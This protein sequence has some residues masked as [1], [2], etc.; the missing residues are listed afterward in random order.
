MPPSFPD[1]P[2][3]PA[4][5]PYQPPYKN[6][7][8]APKLP[9]EP[10]NAEEPSV[11]ELIEA[12]EPELEELDF[13]EPELIETGELG[14][15]EPELIETE[16]PGLEELEFIEAEEPELVEA[17]PDI[18]SEE[19]PDDEEPFAKEAPST[20]QSEALKPDFVPESLEGNS[21]ILAVVKLLNRL[22]ELVKELPDR[23]RESF[24][25]GNLQL[26]LDS[27]IDSLKNIAIIKELHVNN[28]AL[29]D[30]EDTGGETDGS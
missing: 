14:F 7:K 12:K 21:E 5:P 30:G 8:A 18:L 16:E 10:I 22:K 24:F 1:Y 2:Q 28:S 29:N 20:E 23:E 19:I 4:Y 6:E 3:F 27:V 25:N 26:S 15:Q 13:E 17:E 9:E 11:Q